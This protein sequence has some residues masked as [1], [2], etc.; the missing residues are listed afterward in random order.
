MTEISVSINDVFMVDVTKRR[1]RWDGQPEVMLH[2]SL[3]EEPYQG[4][5]N[6]Y[7]FAT[8]SDLEAVLVSALT[9]LNEITQSQ[10]DAVAEVNAALDGKDPA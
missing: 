6:I 2:L 7:L 1:D 10:V 5:D 4:S 8:A 9:Q 3:T